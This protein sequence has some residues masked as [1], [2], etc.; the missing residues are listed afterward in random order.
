MPIYEIASALLCSSVVSPVMMVMDTAILRSQF[1]KLNIWQSYRIT[2]NDYKTGKIAYSRPLGIMNGVY[3]GTYVSANLTE[4]YCKENHIENKRLAI[5]S[6][7]SLINIL[8]ITY[9]DKAYLQMFEKRILHLPR[10]SYLLFMMRDCL[11]VGSTFVLK[12]DVMES[13]HKD[14]QW[15]YAV[16]DFMASF[17]VP[18]MAQFVSTPLHIVSYDLCQHPSRTWI[19]RLQHISHL[20]WPVCAGRILRVIPSFCC[21]SYLND[22]LRANRYFLD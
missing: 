14:Y 13:L 3:F 19:Q 5:F 7:T 15:S 6:V 16:A 9:K 21:G 10:S 11:T 4:L 20:Y 18:I 22:M 1:E 12:K 17:T 2:W 8:A